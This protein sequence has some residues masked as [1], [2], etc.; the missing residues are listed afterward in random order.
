MFHNRDN[1]LQ[2]LNEELLAEEEEWLEEEEV[3]Y[4]AEFDEDLL[5]EEFDF[6]E[7]EEVDFCEEDEL[8]ESPVYRNH[9]NRYGRG[10][11]KV[12]D[13]DDYE[14]EDVLDDEDYLYQRDYKKAKKKKNRGNLGYVILAFLELIVIAAVGIWW[15]SWIW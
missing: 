4:E 1:R 13:F 15:L 2:H 5:T 12:F 8:E 9:A 11:P 10:S 6:E 3:D 7:N 14:D